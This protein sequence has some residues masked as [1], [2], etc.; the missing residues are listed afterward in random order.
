MSNTETTFRP[1]KA[2]APCEV[3]GKGDWCRRSSDGAIECH[4]ESADVAGF[5][6]LKV[7]Q[8]GYGLYRR[9]SDPVLSQA[10]TH[11]PSPPPVRN[12]PPPAPP[13]PKPAV[14]ANLEDYE[15]TLGKRHGGTWLYPNADGSPC[16]AEVRENL[17]DGGKRFKVLHSVGNGWAW[18]D[19]PG[20]SPIYNL[21]AVTDAEVVYVMEGPKC[22]ALAIE[23]GL[24]ATTNPHGGTAASKANWQPLAGREVIVIPD[25]DSIGEKHAA[26]VA[27]IVTALHPPARAKIVR[28]PLENEGDDFEQFKLARTPR[29]VREQIAALVEAAEW[30]TP[31]PDAAPPTD[32]LPPDPGPSWVMI[33]ELASKPSYRKGLIPVSSGFETIDHALGGGWRPE[34]LNILAGRTGSA[35]STF[36]ANAARRMAIAGKHVLYFALE[37]SIIEKGW[38]IHAAAS[39]VEFRTLLN[40]A[41]A[42]TDAERKKLNDGWSLVRTLPIRFSDARDLD[43]ICRISKAHADQAGDA[44]IIDQLSMITVAGADI[45]YQKATLASNRLRTLAVELH[46]PIVLIAQVSRESSKSKEKLTSNSLR[47]SGELENDSACVLM[48]DRVREPD[49]QW[50]GAEPVRILEMLATK[51]RYGATTHTDTPLELNWYPRTCRIEEPERKPQGGDL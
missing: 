32:S 37:E 14:F 50:R 35:K 1:V 5:R 29:E 25:N 22:C 33:G 17:P 28:L 42:A 2:D 20:P 24:I 19:C 8:S 41:S 27:R 16:M 7:T 4:R 23:C 49:G 36:A 26:D 47:D 40:G 31:T 21:P 34:T 30:H 6:K 13:G 44:I 39:Q 43:A 3:C 10:P 9:A 46:V 18:G 48:I 12:A 45:G 51:N 11:R 15:R 38:R